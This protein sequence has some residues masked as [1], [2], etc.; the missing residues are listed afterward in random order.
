M[1]FDERYIQSRLNRS[2]ET[3]E[4]A[5]LLFNERHYLTVI[6]RLY[7]AMFYLVCA[8][9]GKANI[10]AKTHSGTKSQFY[11]HFVKNNI[12]EEDFSN[13]YNSLFQER[14]ENDYGDFEVL[15]KEDVEIL[16]NTT[17]KLLKKYWA[18]FEK[19]N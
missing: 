13:L 8:Y 9:L 2:K 3:L 17:E 5:K 11:L 7:Y 1:S 4:E 6:N 18:A 15:A 16:L 12:V 10:V 19:Y 14:N